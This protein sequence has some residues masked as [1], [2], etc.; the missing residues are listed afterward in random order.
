MSSSLIRLQIVMIRV[1][2]QQS[3]MNN[4]MRENKIQDEPM[5]LRVSVN[6]TL[7]TRKDKL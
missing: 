6:V 5:N 3:N 4:T 2:I 7:G 1:W